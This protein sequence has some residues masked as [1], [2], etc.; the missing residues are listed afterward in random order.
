MKKK[1]I[2]IISLQYLWFPNEAGP[3]RFFY[4]ANIFQK[5]G[6]DV[7]VITGTF[8][9]YTKKVRD[10]QEIL[11]ANYPFKI[12]FINTPKYKKNV[13]FRRAYSNRVAKNRVMKY[14]NKSHDYDIVYVS[15][16]QNEIAASVTKFCHNNDIPVIVDIEDLWPE[17]MRLLIPNKTLCNL[18]FHSYLH[19]AET[20]YKYASAVIGTSDD[21]TLR[22]FKNNKKKYPSKTVFVGCD[23]DVFDGG[24]N[25]YYNEIIKEENE[26][27]VTYAGSIGSSYDIKT[28]ILAG[29]ELKKYE[30]IKI[31][32]LGTGPD[33]EELE[34]ILLEKEIT[35]V[36]FCG[37]TPYLKMAAFLKKSDVLINS[38][39]KGAPQSI[40]NKV[41]DYFA[42]G[43][44]VINTLENPVFCKL[45]EENAVGINIEPESVYALTNTVLKLAENNDLIQ[46]MS[47]AS[48]ELAEQKFDRK[49]SYIEIVNLANELLDN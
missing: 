13:D 29:Q 19:A 6:Y 26:F 45:I 34:K 28:L 41:G 20:T 38:F 25:K 48:R 44:P 14:L 10:C 15:I 16:P 7:E 4:L 22:A 3:S 27:W 33:K 8:E 9:H 40:V 21:Y 39:V 47:E 43:K 12:K 30:N 36:E 5:M 37:Y 11:N 18:F 46:R 31:K 42:A 24:A 1:R 23:L 32:I 2:A 49:T 17:G 35:N